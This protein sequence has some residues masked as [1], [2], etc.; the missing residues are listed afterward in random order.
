MSSQLPNSGGSDDAW[1]PGSR[2]GRRGALFTTPWSLADCAKSV[3]GPLALHALQPET[4]RLICRIL[5]R[6]LISIVRQ[7]MPVAAIRCYLIQILRSTL[8]CANGCSCWSPDEENSPQSF[9]YHG[10]ALPTE[11]GGQVTVLR[12]N[13]DILAANA[14]EGDTYIEHSLAYSAAADTE[15]PPHRLA[16]GFLISSRLRRPSAPVSPRPSAGLG[17]VRVRCQPPRPRREAGVGGM[18]WSLGRPAPRPGRR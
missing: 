13:T 6:K 9:P 10:C 4:S 18:G 3:S 15:S 12:L 11:L 5:L 17:R 14:R 16:S 8:T 2:H 1:S 7:P